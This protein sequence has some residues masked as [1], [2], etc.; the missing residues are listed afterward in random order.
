M[1]Q[2][3]A[4]VGGAVVGGLISNHGAK[5]AAQIQA[6]SANRATDAQ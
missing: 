5:R 6:D 3:A 4:V 2:A 1:P